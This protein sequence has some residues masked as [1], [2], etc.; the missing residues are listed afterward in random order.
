VYFFFQKEAHRHNRTFARSKMEGL[1]NALIL[2][3]DAFRLSAL[4]RDL[5]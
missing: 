3:V 5:Y 4:L 1:F 2:S